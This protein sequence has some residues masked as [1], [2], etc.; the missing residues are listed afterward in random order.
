MKTKP[1]TPHTDCQAQWRRNESDMFCSRRTQNLV[2]AELTTKCFSRV[3]PIYKKI[4]PIKKKKKK[5]TTQ[6]A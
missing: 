2:V 3:E 6:N 5:R 4:N 1:Q